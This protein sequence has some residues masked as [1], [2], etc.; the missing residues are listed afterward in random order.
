[1]IHIVVASNNPV[2]LAAVTNGF[3]SVY[4]DDIILHPVVHLDQT[5]HVRLSGRPEARRELAVPQVLRAA[6]D[7]I[8]RP[9]IRPHEP[10]SRRER[11]EEERLD[12][13][14][15]DAAFAEKR[16]PNWQGK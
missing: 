5:I 6:P 16:A 10:G 13:E 7:Q 11:N 8:E 12:G 15:P 1:M 2:K 14:E 4:S 9:E 3:T